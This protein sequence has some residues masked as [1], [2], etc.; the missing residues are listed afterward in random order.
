M[1]NSTVYIEGI[2]NIIEEKLFEIPKRGIERFKKVQDKIK[3]HLDRVI[4]IFQ[5]DLSN[6][7]EFFLAQ[8]TNVRNVIDAVISDIHLNT[9]RS[10]KTY[11]DVYERFG[12][13]RKIISYVVFVSIITVSLTIF[14]DNLSF[15]R[16]V[17]Y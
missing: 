3:V 4:P 9:L 2:K 15:Q 10:S 13:D 7:Q 8:A 12:P 16:Y 17:L 14:A 6:G 11:D 5:R 1:P